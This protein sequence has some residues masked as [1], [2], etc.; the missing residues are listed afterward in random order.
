MPNMIDTPSNDELATMCA[1]YNEW[2]AD[3]PH[4]IDENGDVH[5]CVGCD[6]ETQV[7]E[8]DH[9]ATPLCHLCAQTWVQMFAKA[10]P[11]LL[12]KS[13]KLEI[14]RDELLAAIARISQTEPLPDEV[15]NALDRQGALVAE[16]GTL[17]ARCAEVERKLADRDA[18]AV[19]W[20]PSEDRSRP[21]ARRRR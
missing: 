10:V 13:A 11:T 4:A 1:R 8:F 20:T 21:R 6:A 5:K 2:E 17:R 9:D 12:D 16:V 18:A 14:R 7:E 3:A 19:A 15:K